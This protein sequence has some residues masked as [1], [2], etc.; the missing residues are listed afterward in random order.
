VISDGT[1]EEAAVE[2]LSGT[3][4]AILLESFKTRLDFVISILADDDAVELF[5]KTELLLLLLFVKELLVS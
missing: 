3:T 4:D 1:T 5:I 2:L